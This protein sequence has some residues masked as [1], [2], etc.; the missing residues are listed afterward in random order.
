MWCNLKCSCPDDQSEPQ[1]ALLQDGRFVVT[2]ID[3][4][5]GYKQIVAS[6]M[7]AANSNDDVLEGD[8]NANTLS[9]NGGVDVIY[10]Y[11]GDDSF[12]GP[13]AIG[14][15][16]DGGIDTDTD[17]VYFTGTAADYSVVN[18]GGSNL[19]TDNRVDSPDGEVTLYNIETLVFSD[20][21]MSF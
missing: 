19:V 4:P 8:D 10:G 14:S 3:E 9:S 11:A 6:I 17:T 18:Q 7:S 5:S 20:S 1:H 13:F 15:I 21:Q 2:Y 12:A 16:V